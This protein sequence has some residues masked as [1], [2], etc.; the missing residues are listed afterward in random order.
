MKIN[1]T[2]KEYRALLDVIQIADWVINSHETEEREDTEEF[3]ALF[4]KLLSHAEEMGFAGLVERS[5]K[6]GKYYATFNFETESVSEQLIQEFE[7]NS[8]WEELI[9]RLGRRDALKDKEAPSI[10]EVSEEEW[11]S[12][13]TAAEQKWAKEFEENDLDRLVVDKAV[14]VLKV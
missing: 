6:D 8:F 1:F 11:F 9:A 4:Q 7:N 10:V 13:L 3:D 14:K 2:K 5:S 12:A